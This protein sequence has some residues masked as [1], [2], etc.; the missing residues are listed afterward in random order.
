MRG[1]MDGVKCA[2]VYHRLIGLS[3]KM[4]PE[5]LLKPICSEAVLANFYRNA[6]RSAV[7]PV[8][9]YIVRPS[10]KFRYR[11]HIGWNS[12]KIISWP[13]IA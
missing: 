11:D 9:Q 1:E 13:H 4:L 6:T 8:P 12:S 2:D 7:M 10:V 3:A 5:F